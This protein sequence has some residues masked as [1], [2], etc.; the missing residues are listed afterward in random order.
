MMMM[1]MVDRRTS[2]DLGEMLD[3]HYKVIKMIC[4]NDIEQII[5]SFVSYSKQS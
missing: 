2:V 1:M 4:S 3:T 5:I